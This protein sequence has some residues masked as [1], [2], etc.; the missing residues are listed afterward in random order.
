MK[1]IMIIFYVLI[2]NMCLGQT[3]EFKNGKKK[4]YIFKDFQGTFLL[5]DSSSYTGSV[6][7]LSATDITVETTEKMKKVIAIHDILSVNYC[8]SKFGTANKSYGT[9][10]KDVKLKDYKYKLTTE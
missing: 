7:K 3:L 8:R 1:T 10:C 4:L 5:N 6:I 9:H 2:A